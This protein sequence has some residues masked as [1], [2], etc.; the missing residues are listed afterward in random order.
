MVASAHVQGR[1]GGVTKG[2][3]AGMYVTPIQYIV[4][5]DLRSICEISV[6]LSVKRRFNRYI[7]NSRHPNELDEYQL[8]YSV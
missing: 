1:D 7:C 3:I 8:R 2:T 4:G 5:T 6:F